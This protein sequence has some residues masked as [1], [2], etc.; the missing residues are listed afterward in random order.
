[1]DERV[2]E[3]QVWL[4]NT[5]GDHSGY[6]T[7]VEDG[8]TG[9]STMYALTRALQIELGITNTADNFGPGTLSRLQAYGPISRTTNNG[10]VNIVKIIQGGCY[11]KGYGPGGITGYF[12]TGTEGAIASMQS[13]MGLLNSDGVVTPKVFKALL[14]MDAYVLLYGGR[15]E[16]RSIQQWLNRMYHHREN[17]FFMPCDG[18][19]R[20]NTQKALVYAIQYEEG[21]SDD[22]ANGNFGPTTRSLLPTL[23]VGESDGT[24]YFVH[25]FQAAMIFNRYDVAFDGYFSSALSGQVEAFQEF[26]MLP[27]TGI[28]DYQTWC[29]LLVSTGDPTRR[30]ESCDCITEITP[31]R[32]STLV[33]E[34]YETVGRYLTNVE[35]GLNKKIQ[36]G[37]LQNIFDAGLTVFP[38]FQ[39]YGGEASYFNYA[40]GKSDAID[41]CNA[42]NDYGFK[43][44]TTIYFAVDF[45]ALGY[46]ITENIIPYF[47]GINDHMS[48]FAGLYK[49]GI[50]GPR[51][52][53]IQVSEEGFATTSFVAGM[54]YG[55]SGNLGYPLPRNWAFDQ[56]STISLGSGD[57]YIEIDNNIKSGRDNGSSSVKT[58][59]NANEDCFLQLSQIQ[60]L[61][62]YHAEVYY[63]NFIVP[64]GNYLVT[65]YYRKD[66]YDKFRWDITAGPVNNEFVG[67]AEGQLGDP[68]FINLTDPVTTNE[69]GIEHLMA[70][71]SADLYVALPTS[72]IEAEVTA[73]AGWAGDLVQLWR[74]D[75]YQ[76][77][78]EYGG[79]VYQC[80]LDFIGAVNVGSYSF[81]DLAGDID[82]INIAR[83]LL[84]AEEPKTIFEAVEEYYNGYVSTRF[85]QFF[86][87][88]FGGS[89][90][91]LTNETRKYV[92]EDR[93]SLNFI[94]SRLLDSTPRY[95]NEEGEQ[96]VQAFVDVF[97]SFLEEE[98]S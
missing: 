10:N 22:I 44:G 15:P 77:K 30:G 95:S 5:Y 1:M 75:I 46:Q 19:Y 11:C 9:W 45:D 36:P 56:I 93:A 37:E 71:M 84:E 40:Q 41:A 58:D 50:Y 26:T 6:E 86:Q 85:S 18:L 89:T 23:N 79:D 82:A 63:P 38:I 28:G 72:E 31:A 61:G 51:N 55:F 88:R 17:F 7:I 21:L 66:N 65:N 76:R 48:D 12:G 13:D 39:T 29:S 3:T 64:Y 59:T 92:L 54:S 14:T 68:A 98:Q 8:I 69:V 32:A 25:L 16:V 90:D 78:D 53:C 57:G 34:G 91:I 47:N 94:R 24:T 83:M 73:F 27:V 42:A 35:G 33:N 74:D 81:S 96:L 52:V 70:T 67:W 87:H 80:A 2:L 60:V 97:L 43:R 20:R 62:M 4:N 49:V